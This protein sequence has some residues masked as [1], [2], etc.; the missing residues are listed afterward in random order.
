MFI[1]C[2]YSFMYWMLGTDELSVP[3]FYNVPTMTIF[4]LLR[5][6]MLWIEFDREYLVPTQHGRGIKFPIWTDLRYKYSTQ[7]SL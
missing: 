5:L 7:F 4:L 3:M 1:L 6:G 2:I